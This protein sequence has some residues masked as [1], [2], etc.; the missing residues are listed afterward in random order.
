MQA[1]P[2][3]RNIMRSKDVHSLGCNME[4]GAASAAC[5]RR[6]SDLRAARARQVNPFLI[7]PIGR[8]FLSNALPWPRSCRWA[9]FSMSLMAMLPASWDH[10]GKQSVLVTER[11][12]P[13]SSRPSSRAPTELPRL[14]QIGCFQADSF[15]TLAANRNPDP[16]IRA[17]RPSKHN[18][19]RFLRIMH[20][21]ATSALPCRASPMP[22]ACSS[23][24][25]TY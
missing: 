2:P 22:P 18:L 10:N 17:V 19:G 25:L 4:G 6:V 11:A 3:A 12:K 13:A 16:I 15:L 8:L 9:E 1:R 23:V 24:P 21:V 20:G 5:G 7:A 14:K